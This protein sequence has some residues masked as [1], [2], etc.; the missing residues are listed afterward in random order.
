MRRLKNIL[1]VAVVLGIIAVTYRPCSAAGEW[2][3]IEQ[4]I[5]EATR[6]ANH[7]AVATLYEQEARKA[8]DLAAK[9]LLMREVYAAARAV[10]RKD[11]A[12]E[13]YAFIAKTY[14]EMANEYE[15]IAAVHKAMAVQPK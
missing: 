8:R 2:K 9:Y 1:G 12:G 6:P 5:R 7:Y 15:I 4:K 13:P 10:E 3:N 11:R 14:Q